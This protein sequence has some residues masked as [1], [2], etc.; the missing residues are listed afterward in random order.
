MHVYYQGVR[1]ELKITG[2][3]DGFDENG[4]PVVFVSVEAVIPP[5]PGGPG[6]P[7]ELPMAA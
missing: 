6:E 5:G 7:I 4:A 2:T 3:R 1:V